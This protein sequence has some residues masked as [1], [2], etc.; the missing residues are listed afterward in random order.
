[1]HVDRQGVAGLWGGGREDREGGR[2]AG[3]AAWMTWRSETGG[4]GHCLCV[5]GERCWRG[6]GGGVQ[7][8][9]ATSRTSHMGWGTNMERGEGSQEEA[10]RT[11]DIDNITTG[12]A[13]L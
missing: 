11:A 1:M 8:E 2:T 5:L 13:H 9:A 4:Q 10:L 3:L 7:R 6:G 12:T